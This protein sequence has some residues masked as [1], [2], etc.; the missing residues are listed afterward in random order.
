LEHRT[1]ARTLLSLV[2][3]GQGIATLA[4]DLN[5][6]HASNP[7]WLRH[8]RFHVVWQTFSTAM[9]SVLEI[10]L[11]CWPGAYGEQRFYL[12]VVLTCLPLLAFFVAFFSRR[13]YGGALSDPN[14]IP[15]ARLSLFGK[16]H[17]V[18]LNVVAVT[19]ALPVV[20]AAF[21]IYVL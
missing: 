19:V 18:D 7:E 11:V 15:P 2:C 9:L 1:L 3:I 14:G 13:L 16:V 6:T 4:I 5:R 17:L 8:A 20:A 12:A 21:A 10:A